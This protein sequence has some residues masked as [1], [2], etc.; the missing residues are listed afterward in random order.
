MSVDVDSHAG[1]GMGTGADE[2]VDAFG[3]VFARTDGATPLLTAAAG[4][5]AGAARLLLR[6]LNTH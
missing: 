1:A 2:F 3:E 5:H 4:G 6:R